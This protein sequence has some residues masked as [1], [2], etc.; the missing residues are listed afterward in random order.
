[1]KIYSGALLLNSGK[2]S[3]FVIWQRYNQDHLLTLYRMKKT[4]LL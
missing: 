1:M 3:A 4:N 2:N